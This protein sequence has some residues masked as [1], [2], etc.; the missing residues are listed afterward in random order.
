MSGRRGRTRAVLGK[1]QRAKVIREIAV[2]Q[3]EAAAAISGC[4]KN[5]RA[6]RL[7]LGIVPWSVELDH[8]SAW[9]DQA[10]VVSLAGRAT[11]TAALG[12]FIPAQSSWGVEPS[13][14]RI[15]PSIPDN[16]T[17]IRRVPVAGI[18]VS[19]SAGGVISD[20]GCRDRLGP[21]A[22]EI[23]GKGTTTNTGV[24]AGMNQSAAESKSGQIERTM[25]LTNAVVGPETL[26]NGSTCPVTF[27]ATILGV[28][29]SCPGQR[30]QPYDQTILMLW[31]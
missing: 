15:W 20:H 21:A 19:V 28:S 17:R 1:A 5:S 30:C 13:S 7:V 12:W 2:R 16:R 14:K 6:R 18:A 31:S 22:S 27:G 9:P 25:G 26:N 24:V 3:P 23:G 11:D 8:E 4:V 10:D 29:I